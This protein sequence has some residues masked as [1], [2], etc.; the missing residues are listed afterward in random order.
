MK[1]VVIKEKE[2]MGKASMT[3]KTISLDVKK[4]NPQKDPAES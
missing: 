3:A 1:S 4:I 2:G